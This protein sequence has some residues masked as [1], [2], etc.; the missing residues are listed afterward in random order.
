MSLQGDIIARIPFDKLKKLCFEPKTREEE[1]IVHIFDCQWD[2]WRE[3]A[4]VK[5]GIPYN[6][7]DIPRYVYP[8]NVAGINRYIEVATQVKPSEISGIEVYEN[9]FIK[10]VYEKVAL[11]LEA[12][13]RDDP[14]IITEF[15]K[16]LTYNDIEYINQRIEGWTRFSGYLYPTYALI[17]LVNKTKGKIKPP[18]YLEKEDKADIAEWAKYNLPL[19]ELDIEVTYQDIEYLITKGN[20]SAFEYALEDGL[21]DN[22]F[23][24]CLQSGKLEFVD[25]ILSKFVNVSEGYS[26]AKNIPVLDFDPKQKEFPLYELEHTEVTIDYTILRSALIGGNVQI[27]DF[28]RSY[29]QLVYLPYEE[30]SLSYKGYLHRGNPVEYY[31]IIQRFEPKLNL[32]LSTFGTIDVLSHVLYNVTNTFWKSVI[33]SNIGNITSLIEIIKLYEKSQNAVKVRD[34]LFNLL[35]NFIPEV[36]PLS[37]K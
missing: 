15:A 7:F 12:I 19:D 11:V 27:V 34:V 2:L 16:D 28:F 35:Y 26:I 17:V 37:K 33:K 22:F 36:Y 29:Y 5:F 13:K 8:R 31:S 3:R 21:I 9:G 6:Y 18:H 14:K 1:S 24:L 30:A 25:P 32:N 23:L 20:T 10:G 4:R